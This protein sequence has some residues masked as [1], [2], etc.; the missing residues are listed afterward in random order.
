[1]DLKEFSPTTAVMSTP[2]TGENVNSQSTL[3]IACVYFTTDQSCK[4]SKIATYD[5]I[6][7]LSS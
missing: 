4:N 7:K 6:K 1:M 2:C 5:V 3:C